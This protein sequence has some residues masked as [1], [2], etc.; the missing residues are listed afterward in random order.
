MC[1]CLEWKPNVDPLHP[2]TP[3]SPLAM[4]IAYALHRTRLHVFV[5]FTNIYLLQPLKVQ[6]PTTRDFS[7]HQLF[8]S[9]FIFALK[10]I[11][12]N[13]Y[14]N[15]LWSIVGQSMFALHEINQMECEMCSYLE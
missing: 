7:R 10:V 14:S 13:T 9:T 15:K 4:F 2:S 11:C 3:S 12:N 5:T 6:F 1:F 8:I